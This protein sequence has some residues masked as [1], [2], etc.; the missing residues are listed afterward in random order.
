MEQGQVI[1]IFETKAAR[2]ISNFIEEFENIANELTDNL[3][4][5]M[6]RSHI[7]YLTV[8]LLHRAGLHQEAVLFCN[9]SPMEHV[10]IFGNEFY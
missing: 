2:I 5:D 8:L 6:E 4:M 3:I 10:Q 1:Q 7:P 9:Q